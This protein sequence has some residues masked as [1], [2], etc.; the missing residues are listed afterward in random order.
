MRGYSAVGWREGGGWRY[1]GRYALRY[2]SMGFGIVYWTEEGEV[3][4]RKSK[5]VRG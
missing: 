3:E 4:G 1:W 5:E 2:V